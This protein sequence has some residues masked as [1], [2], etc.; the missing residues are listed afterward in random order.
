MASQILLAFSLDELSARL[1]TDQTAEWTVLTIGHW[2]SEELKRIEAAYPGRSAAEDVKAVRN[3]L[4]ADVTMLFDLAARYDSTSLF[5]VSAGV[6]L[7][8]PCWDM[9]ERLLQLRYQASAASTLLVLVEAEARQTDAAAVL[10][11][12][13]VTVPKLW[14]RRLVAR[15]ARTFLRRMFS[16]RHSPK[17]Q[18]RRKCWVSVGSYLVGSNPDPYFARW[19]WQG[20][21]LPLRVYQ[22]GGT[23][24][25][26]PSSADQIPLESLLHY[27]D[28]LRAVKDL[29]AAFRL[30]RS[31]ASDDFNHRLLRWLWREEIRR[32]DVLTLAFQRRAWAR[33][34]TEY[35]PARLIVPYEA[36]AWERSLVRQ[37]RT[38]GITT[39]GY[40]HS[41]LTPRHHAILVRPSRELPDWVPD[42]IICCGE[43]TAKRLASAAAVYR[44][45]LHVGAALRTSTTPPEGTGPAI[46]VA[47][48]SSRHEA[49]ALFGIFAVAGRL[50]LRCPLIFR[51]HPTIPVVDLYEQ[52]DWPVGTRFSIGRSL[53]QDLSESWCVAYS[54]ATVSLEG[55]LHGRIPV[56]VD[57]GE[58]LSGDPLDEGLV[59]KLTADSPE[60][61]VSSIHGFLNKCSDRCLE[62]PQ[63]IQ[64]A[65]SY[66]IEAT[67][68]RISSMTCSVEDA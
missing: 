5:S 9:V 58:I 30:C 35:K 51:P 2:P 13:S 61:L 52:W 14:S 60:N 3:R 66:L 50:G 39:I 20:P 57:I 10:A 18:M 48:S 29:R 49:R 26:L 33:L 8:I 42:R 47:L 68:E 43:V 31:L 15:L 22:Q 67:D 24:V 6:P 32:G 55:M 63:A 54:S 37:A 28:F 59:F 53:N 65:K 12:C 38:V 27:S 62:S 34:L 7:S 46:L 19:P 40:Q 17:T 11:G 23:A 56:Y 64:Y 36:R 41:S 16:R 1:S 21:S 25:R 4:I 44:G 45:R